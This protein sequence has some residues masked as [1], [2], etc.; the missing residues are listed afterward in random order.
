MLAK[1]ADE[2]RVHPAR[3]VIFFICL[4]AQ[5]TWAD[6]QSEVETIVRTAKLGG[7][8]ASVCVI[9]TKTGKVLVDINSTTAMIPASNQ[10]LLTS[11]SALHILG[12]SFAFKT[13]LLWNEKTKVLTVVGDG[14]PT[15]G[16]ASLLGKKNWA[17]ENQLLSDELAP[18]IEAVKKAGIENIQT[19]VVDDRIFDRSFVHPSWPANQINNW[20]CAQVSGLNY[21]LNVVH[22]FPAPRSNQ[23]AS[24]GEIA[25]KMPWITFGN[26]TTSKIGKKDNSSFWVARPPNSNKITARGNVKGVHIEPVKVAFHNPAIVF[27]QV[28]ARELRSENISVKNVEQVPNDAPRSDNTLIFSHRTP[29][30]TVLRRSNSDSHNLYAE[31]L[32]K[33]IAAES[34]GRSGTFDEGAHAVARAV[35]QRL[36]IHPASLVPADGSGMSR[37]NK[38]STQTLALWLASFDTEDQAGKMLLHSLA[39]PGVGTLKSRFSKTAFAEIAV[40]AKSGYLSGICSLSGYITFENHEPLV[41]SIIVNNIKGTVKEAKKMQE[42]IIFASWDEIINN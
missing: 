34:T 29:L 25:P 7:G 39:T 22:F 16:D 4:L 15:I 20:Y 1:H 37:R 3:I 13:Q 33:R 23:K 6:L 35:S 42:S 27:G 2:R 28:L 9:D 10:K 24:L 32:L 19:V 30:N 17:H 5:A 36:N 18:W 12:P 21:H 31:A 8:T 41:F 14:D 26:K 38:V 11:G 40:Y